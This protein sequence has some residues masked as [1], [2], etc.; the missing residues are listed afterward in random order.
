MVS[1]VAR[2]FCKYLFI[3]LNINSLLGRNIAIERGYAFATGDS[4][5][6]ILCVGGWGWVMGVVTHVGVVTHRG[7]LSGWVGVVGEDKTV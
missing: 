2:L 3:K 1:C 6:Y 4:N 5:E 7:G